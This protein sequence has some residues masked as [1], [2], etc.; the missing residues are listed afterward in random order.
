MFS[1]RSSIART[2]AS[3]RIDGRMLC[4]TTF[5][6]KLYNWCRALGFTAGKIMPSRAFCSDESQGFPI[7]LL[8]KHFGAFPFNHGRVGGIVSVE[9]H[10]PF[11]EH[12]KD[13]LLVHASHVGY[14]PETGRFGTYR[15][16][17]TAQ[18][19]MTASCGKIG[20]ILE[21]YRQELDY[22]Q[23]NIRLTREAGRPA[24]AI[25]N[26]LLSR[27]RE[28]GLFLIPERLIEG[29]SGDRL[30][31]PL[32]AR[33]TGVV[34]AAGAALIE[35]LGAAAWPGSGSRAIGAGLAPEDFYFRRPG[36]D[37]GNV[38]DQLECNLLAPMPW[39]LTAAHPYLTAACANTQAEFDRTY[40]SLAR[41]PAVQGKN[42]LFIGGLN[43]DISPAVG[44]T[45]PLTRFVP[46]A[47]FR[48]SADGQREL[49]EQDALWAQIEAQP[50][51]NPARIDLE[52]AIQT[53]THGREIEVRLR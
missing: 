26:L 32:A 40:R 14:D 35:R 18:A 30:P 6:A 2:L 12:G 24:L 34:Y 31:E 41:S 23:E 53:M 5:V 10:G 51:D 22:A 15:R 47:A 45:F 43:I 20:H 13:L 1:H 7:I 49:L 36:L 42:L 38:Q 25:D 29:A 37:A 44:E 4:Y 9:R 19:C 17:H 46:W 27:Q 33:S 16:L 8:A 28:A 50:A 11:A 21:Y 3:F 48:Q 39:I 52:Q